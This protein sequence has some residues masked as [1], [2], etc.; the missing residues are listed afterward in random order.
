[1]LCFTIPCVDPLSAVLCGGGRDSTG[2]RVLTETQKELL[3]LLSDESPPESSR[4]LPTTLWEERGEE[5][6][7]RTV[8]TRFVTD[9]MAFNTSTGIY[10]PQPF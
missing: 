6:G 3:K 2:G 10:N 1:M 7:G 9:A 4:Y 5:G 8:G